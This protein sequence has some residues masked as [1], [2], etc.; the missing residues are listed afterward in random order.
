M[1]LA[2][3]ELAVEDYIDPDACKRR[4][5]QDDTSPARSRLRGGLRVSDE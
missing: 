3:S 2:R 4:S 5:P 1:H